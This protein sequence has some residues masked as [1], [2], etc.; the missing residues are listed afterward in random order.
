MPLETLLS[1]NCIITIYSG[2]TQQC[3]VMRGLHMLSVAMTQL[4]TAIGNGSVSERGY[5]SKTVF[6]KTVSQMWPVS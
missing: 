6:M 4:K 1:C 5:S 2:I 3:E